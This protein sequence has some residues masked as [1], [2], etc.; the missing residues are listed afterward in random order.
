MSPGN[1]ASVTSLVSTTSDLDLPDVPT[2]KPL[3]STAQAGT[4]SRMSAGSRSKRPS[5][6]TTPRLTGSCEKNTSAGLIAPSSSSVPARAAL[7]AYLTSTSTPVS[8]ANA[9]IDHIRNWTDATP[10]NDWVS[11]A[12]CSDGSYGVEE[13]LIS[14][15]PVKCSNGDWEIVQD[16]EID[17]FSKKKIDASV[18]EL[19][20][21]R[22]TV[23]DLNLI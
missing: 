16:L 6:A 9:A 18:K 8:A 15:F 4:L 19:S 14:S 3:L 7:F 5:L 1:S 12:V 17:D 10:A 21:E 20:E 22:D 23:S 11:M 13:G 2:Q